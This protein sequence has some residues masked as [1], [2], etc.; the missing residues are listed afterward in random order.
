MK[1][2]LNS[3]KRLRTLALLFVTSI[4][5][6]YACKQV[7]SS[8]EE[9]SQ[10]AQTI[11]GLNINVKYA[12][13]YDQTEMTF[14]RLWPK[15]IAAGL[16]KQS[17]T[18][19]EL[20]VDYER[21]REVLAFDEE[22][23]MSSISEFLEGDGEMNMPEEAYNK[24]KATMPARSADHD[25][26]VKTV[27]QDGT[28]KSYSKSGKLKYE[29]TYDPEEFR[30]DPALLDLLETAAADTS[31]V[32]QSI[33]NNK[34]GLTNDG[35]SFNIVD[36]FYAEYEISSSVEAQ[37]NGVPAYQLLQD[38]RTGDIVSSA[39][40]RADGEYDS[41]TFNR[42]KV[43][44]NTSILV[45]SEEFTFGNINGKWGVTQRSVMH[46]QNIKVIK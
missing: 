22:G 30:V 39:V 7:N 27:M 38:L 9:D 17:T 25:P 23:Y 35:I 16:G 5:L 20:L 14:S 19:G 40:L 8:F 1:T 2:H 21:T 11:E 6:T 44:E 15:G 4:V 31:D 32:E 37:E 24:H 41:I 42:F 12:E 43:V 36:G 29:S 26:V 33:Q 3:T 13:S 45:Y 34:E 10:Q 28:T 18:G 46:R